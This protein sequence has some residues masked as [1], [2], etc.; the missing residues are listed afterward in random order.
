MLKDSQM[1]PVSADLAD[2][3]TL[4]KSCYTDLSIYEHEKEKI[5]W[6]SWQCVGRVEQLAKKGDFL[7]TDVV[8]EP[9]VLM[10]DQDDRLDI[11]SNVCRHRATVMAKGHGNFNCLKCPYHGWTYSLAGDL[12][13]A[14]EFDGA[15]NWNPYDVSLPKY[16]VEA[17]GPFLFGHLGNGHPAL[18]E[19]LG[20]I[21][22]E[23]ERKGYNLTKYKFLT[24]REFVIPCN[25]KVY[26]DNYLEGYHLPLVH[27]GLFRELEYKEYHTDTFGYHS[28]QVAPLRRNASKNGRRYVPGP[29]IREPL[30]YWMFP[31][32]MLNIYHDN[33]N[34]NLIVPLSVDKTLT[35]FEWL[36]PEEQ[37]VE[38]LGHIEETIAFTEEIQKEDIAICERVQQGLQSRSYSR[39]RFSVK[40]ENGVHHFHRTWQ[41]YLQH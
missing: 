25:W 24:R 26:V 32:F 39:G 21:P 16:L 36:V 2:A 15:K 11:F 19:M 6:N 17:W 33:V 14:P 40:R 7:A 29:G 37:Y 12:K 8:G 5:F 38:D 13:N 22:A 4:H 9:I 3:S 18:S 41:A 28:S 20:N 31:N 1:H 34:Y 23:V 27:P 10:R 30:Y 35:I